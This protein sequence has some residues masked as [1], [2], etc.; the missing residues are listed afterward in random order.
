MATTSDGGV[1][2]MAGR[3]EPAVEADL[4]F[5]SIPLEHKPFNTGSPTQ[6]N[7]NSLKLKTLYEYMKGVGV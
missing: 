7:Q 2:R 5:L 1:R 6:Q 3:G 4:F